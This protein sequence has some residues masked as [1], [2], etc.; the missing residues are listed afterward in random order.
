MKK[1]KRNQEDDLLPEYDL[2]ALRARKSD[3]ERRIFPQQGVVLASDFASAFPESNAVNEALRFLLRVAKQG[4]AISHPVAD[5]VDRFLALM[6]AEPSASPDLEPLIRTLDEMAWLAHQIRQEETEGDDQPNSD[7][8]VRDHWTAST[9]KAAA[10]VGHV[11]SVDRADCEKFECPVSDLSEIIDDLGLIQ[12]R[13]RSTSEADV[14][15]HYKLGFMTH[16]GHHL[17]RAQSALH[18]W[19]W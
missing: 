4:E 12:W 3:P 2:N 16:W 1:T 13:F 18:A 11:G 9:R 5:A 10:W 7:E 6:D 17:R 19:Y 15:F 14:L 8:P